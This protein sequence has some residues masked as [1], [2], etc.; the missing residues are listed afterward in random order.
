M[1]K[2][3]LSNQDMSSQF[4]RWEE[5]IKTHMAF[6]KSL[7]LVSKGGQGRSICSSSFGANAN[8]NGEIDGEDKQEEDYSGSSSIS[9]RERGYS[10]PHTCLAE[11]VTE[12]A[13]SFRIY[14]EYVDVKVKG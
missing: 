4:F 3:I 8:A 2:K 1:Q 12:F 6:Q 11:V 5:L 13:P 10:C 7:S 14:G 9:H